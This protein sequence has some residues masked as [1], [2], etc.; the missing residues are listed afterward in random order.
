MNYLRKNNRQSRQFLKPFY[1]AVS[2][3]T[4]SSIS[5]FFWPQLFN[6]VLVTIARPFW[7]VRERGIESLE[8]ISAQ[9][10]SK[11]TLYN[12][13]TRLKIAIDIA[14]NNMVGFEI[15]K[16]ENIELKKLLGRV[17][18]EDVVLT[19]ILAKPDRSIYDTLILDVGRNSAI[20]KGDYVMDNDFII[21]TIEEVYKDTSKATLFSTAG[22]VFPV[23]IGKY[24][25]EAEALG[26][27]GGNFSIK[28]PRGVNIQNGDVIVQPGL[29]PK[30]FGTILSIESKSTDTFQT[31]RFVLP[32]NVNYIHWL[33]ILRK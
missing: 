1:I 2:I 29:N 26:L 12:E 8:K 13:N 21:G 25:I 10:R 16:N 17:E 5:Y 24:N 28:L 15:L 27:G 18:K 19:A 4:L 23:L 31:L 7:E 6:Q 14:R 33:L 30:F 20:K 22:N 3:F 32:V 11:E 9:M